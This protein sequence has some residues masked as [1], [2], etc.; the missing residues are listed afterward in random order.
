M[1]VKVEKALAI[2]VYE[3]TNCFCEAREIN[4]SVSVLYD[5]I[6]SEPDQAKNY[7]R[8]YA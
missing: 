2:F 5:N 1:R 4:N 6:K 7:K 8:R 3:K